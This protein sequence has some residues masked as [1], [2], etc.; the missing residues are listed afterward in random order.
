MA[1]LGIKEKIGQGESFFRGSSTARIHNIQ[2]AAEQ[3]N[4]QLVAPGETFSFNQALGEIS[5][6]TGYQ[7]G[8]IIKE[9]QTLP[10]VGGGVCQVS[11]TF[12]RAALNTGLPIEERQAHAYRVGVY[13]QESSPGLDATVYSPS[14]DLKFT[15]DTGYYLLI[16]TVFS[17]ADYHLTVN[18]YGTNDGRRVALTNFQLWDITPPPPALYIEDPTLPNGEIKQIDWAASG[19]KASFDWEVTRDGKILQKE[20]FYSYYQPW[21]A[22]YLR[23][24]KE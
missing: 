5:T 19:A 20:T 1:T 23:G 7:E 9:G 11:T 17:P 18:I 16:E 12:F 15:N 14:P 8:Y 6:I 13:E 21:Q 10:D 4:G 24:T 3:L 2:T 22:K